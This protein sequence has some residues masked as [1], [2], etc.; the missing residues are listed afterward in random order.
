MKKTPKMYFKITYFKDSLEA[1][2]TKVVKEKFVQASTM[3]GVC[4]AFPVGQVLVFRKTPTS[5][6][7]Q[8]G[9]WSN[10]VWVRGSNAIEITKI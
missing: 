4:S 8:V 1:P 3:A 5:R 7:T 10:A 2:Y 6:R 9:D